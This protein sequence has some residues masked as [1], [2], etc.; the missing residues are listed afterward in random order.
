MA[1]TCQSP[2]DRA[3]PLLTLRHGE[4]DAACAALMRLAEHEYAPNLLVGVRTGG[5]VVA[6][7]MARAATSPPPVLPLTSRRQG[8]KL[9]AR[10]PGLRGILTA[11]PRP[12]VDALRQTEHR[13]LSGRRRRAPAAEVDMA[14]AAAIAAWMLEAPPQ[15]VLVADDAVDSGATLAAVLRALRLVCPRW[16][17][18][19][20]AAITVTMRDPLVEPDYVLHRGVLCRFPWSFDA[21]A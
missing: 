21:A 13:L 5:L 11:L 19:R 12:L 1:D 6:E 14:E 20:T 18:I 2:A 4:F 17:E 7:A 9:K 10:I 8:T 3:A 15:R 16:T